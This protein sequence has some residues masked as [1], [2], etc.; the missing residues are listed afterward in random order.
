MSDMRICYDYQIFSRQ[1]FG[2]ISR[3]FVELALRIQK[4]PGTKVRVIAPLYWSELLAAKSDEIPVLGYPFTYRIR[5]AVRFMKKFDPCF[6]RVLSWA[7]KPD[8]VHETFYSRN[9]TSSSSAKT[10]ITVYDMIDELFTAC[11]PKKDKIIDLR[12]AAFSRADHLICISESTRADLIRLYEVD[13]DKVSVIYLASSL[14]API[15]PVVA[16][17]EPY[18]LYVGVRYAHKN[19]PRLLAA[20]AESLLFKTHKLVCFGGGQFADYEQKQMKELGIPPDRIA[21]VDGGNDDLLS[22][23]YASAEAFVCPSIYEGFGIPLLEAMECGCPII[24]SNNSSIPE[25]A[26]DAAIYFDAEDIHSISNAML[27]IAQSPNERNQL[28]MKGKVRCKQFSWDIC[29]QQTYS[30][31]ERLLGRI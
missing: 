11:S 25:V 10:I 8:I 15:G 21:L 13:P 24:C 31:Y 30:V 28:I 22:R 6:S 29:A 12:K 7:Y 17:G 2:G 1:K 9:R 14:T 19:F 18:I 26:G 23:Y 5:G 20:F 4:Y 16:M 27:R 3:Y